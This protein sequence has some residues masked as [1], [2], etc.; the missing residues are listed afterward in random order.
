MTNHQDNQEAEAEAYFILF[1]VAG[2]PDL[3]RAYAAID[4]ETVRQRL[5]ALAEGLAGISS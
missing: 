2:A 1:D 5:L 4:D 3:L